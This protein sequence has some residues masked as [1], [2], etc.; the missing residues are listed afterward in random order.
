MK[1]IGIVGGVAWRSTADY[2]TGICRLSEEWHR[3]RGKTGAL[4][5]PEMS[6]ES[7]DL[8]K[9]ISLL[10]CDENESSWRD[11]DAYHREALVRLEVSGAQLGIIASNTPHH[12]FES[13]VRGI[14]I[15]V[16]NIFEAAARHCAKLGVKEAL[17]LGTSQTMKSTKIRDIFTE[18][19]VA[20]SGPPTDALM[21]RTAQ[22]IEDLQRGESKGAVKRLWD[23]VVKSA[24]VRASSSIAVC[25][26]CTELPLALSTASRAPVVMFNDVG[27]CRFG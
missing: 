19:C 15:P 16:I 14:G 20:A 22:L 2:Y 23:I 4:P 17:I 25:L 18:Y 6:I 9:A 12:R 27:C 3:A 5:T 7:L 11:F 1:K 8:D 10:G 21:T 13:I 26:A 24:P